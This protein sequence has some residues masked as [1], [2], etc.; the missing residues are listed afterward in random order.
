M[1]L[2]MRALNFVCNL[3]KANKIW[4]WRVKKQLERKSGESWFSLFV[5]KLG[6]SFDFANNQK[7]S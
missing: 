5:L 3:R 6:V 7:F 4:F 1:D 2:K